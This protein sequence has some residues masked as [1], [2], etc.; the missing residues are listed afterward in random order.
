MEERTMMEVKHLALGGGG[1]TLARDICFRV[2]PGECLLLAGPNG[3][4]KSTLLRTLA[5]LEARVSPETVHLDGTAV[6]VPTGIPKVKGFTVEAFIRTG[7]YRSSNW[8]GRLRKE[9]ERRLE[10]AME[11][12][13]LTAR[14]GQDLSTLSDGEFQKACMAAGLARKAD[15]LLLD[16]PTAFLD[17][18]TRQ[19]VLRCLADLV[20][21]TGMGVVFSSHDLHDALAAARRVLA[22]TP[23]GGFRESAEE[24][25][26]EVLQE[27]FPGIRL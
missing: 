24:N 7:C 27:A 8:A 19:M 17:V 23:G 21:R 15:I 25:R 22:F 11:L 12:M 14:R 4:G 18:E 2:Q 6:F 5:G 26:L 1:R 9:G 13:G 20:R 3:C 16:E 10:E